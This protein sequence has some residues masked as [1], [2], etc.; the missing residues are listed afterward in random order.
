MVVDLSVDSS[1]GGRRGEEGECERRATECIHEDQDTDQSFGGDGGELRG[2]LGERSGEVGEDGSTRRARS[3]NRWRI[4]LCLNWLRN[5]LWYNNRSVN[6]SHLLANF[7]IES[8]LMCL[9][10]NE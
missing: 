5:R 10:C 3:R 9:V 4:A 2:K 6:L 1:K 7:S 8:V